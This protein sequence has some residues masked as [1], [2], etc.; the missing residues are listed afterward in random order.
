MRGGFGGKGGWEKGQ[1][2]VFRDLKKGNVG[3]IG[4]WKLPEALNTELLIN[5][6]RRNSQLAR[7]AVVTSWCWQ[8]SSAWPILGICNNLR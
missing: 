4:R 3:W 5:G 1:G 2:C 8:R 7:L 6:C